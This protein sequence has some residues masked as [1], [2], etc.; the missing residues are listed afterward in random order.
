LRSYEREPHSETLAYKHLAPLGRN[1]TTSNLLHFKLEYTYN[2]LA[3]YRFTIQIL[4]VVYCLLFTGYCLLST[5][6]RF[7]VA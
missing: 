7:A 6:Y 2:K 3:T 4:P 5:N 1:P